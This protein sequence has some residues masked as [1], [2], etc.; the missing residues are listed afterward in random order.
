M[1]KRDQMLE[2]LN[3]PVRFHKPKSIIRKNGGLSGQ[4]KTA[5]SESLFL[6]KRNEQG[7]M[8]FDIPQELTEEPEEVFVTS[9]KYTNSDFA[10]RNRRSSVLMMKERPY[11]PFLH[12]QKEEEEEKPQEVQPKK[13]NVGRRK[14]NKDE[15]DFGIN[16]NKKIKELKEEEKEVKAEKNIKAGKGK[17]GKKKGKTPKEEPKEEIE[18]RVEGQNFHGMDEDNRL[19]IKINKVNMY[20]T[21][22]SIMIPNAL[23]LCHLLEDDDENLLEFQDYSKKGVLVQ[24]NGIKREAVRLEKERADNGGTRRMSLYQ[25]RSFNIMLNIPDDFLHFME[26]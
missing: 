19:K 21:K 1:N 7:S 8:D 9:D 15:F 3:A 22:K 12:E 5:D 11:L 6:R 20:W 2:N 18:E 10:F 24:G 14:K 13:S 4:R 26:Q 17:S 16:L 25:R 23:R